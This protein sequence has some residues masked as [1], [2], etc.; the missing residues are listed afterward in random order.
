MVALATG[1]VTTLAG[2][3]GAADS[4]DGTGLGARFSSP[5]GLATDGAGNLFV[6]DTGNST[7]R[8]IA[9]ATR[10]VT[11]L[12]G[13]PGVSDSTDGTG[14]AAL[15]SSPEGVASDGAGN[16]FVADTDNGTI[17]RIVI[18]TGAATTLAGSPGDFD[19]A[20]GVGLE[21]RFDHPQGVA[22]DGA[23]NLFVADSF[24]STIR[25]IAAATGAVTTLAGSAKLPGRTDGTGSAARFSFPARLAADGAGSLFVADSYN[26]AIRKIDVTTGGVTTLVGAPGRAAVVLGP[27]PAGLNTPSDVAVG[28]GGALL[29]T[30]EDA[31]LVVR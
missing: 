16:L 26:A 12:A 7:I 22:S 17:R 28:P 25:K 13:S 11:T 19:A 30:D 18:A 23:G 6:A 2:A 3:A 27:L 15:F 31:I 29:V 1:A 10:R 20:D 14:A 21:A 24:N 8:Q 5:H 9:V 4:A